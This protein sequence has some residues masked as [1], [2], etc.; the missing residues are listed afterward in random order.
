M[1]HKPFRRISQP[2]EGYADA[3]EAYNVTTRSQESSENGADIEAEEA[4]YQLAIGMRQTTKW[5][6]L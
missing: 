3:V 1:L 4:N 2:T 5:F 6:L